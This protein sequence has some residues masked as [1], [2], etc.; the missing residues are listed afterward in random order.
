MALVIADRVRETTTT[1]GTGDYT[2][3]GA[4]G[5]YQ[6]F[7]D[8]CSDG[9]TTYYVVTD[10]TDWEIGV[11][12][13]T[14]SGTTLARTAIYQSS[15]SDAAVNWGAGTKQVFITVPADKMTYFD[16]SGGSDSFDPAGTAV[17]LAIALG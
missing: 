2:L 12:T 1:T 7:S 4:V 9:D 17:A 15:N 13:F 16:A 10:N 3:A 8:V 6:S 11:A 5:G 14:L